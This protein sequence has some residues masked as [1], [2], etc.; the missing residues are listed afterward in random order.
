MPSS[1]IPEHADRDFTASS[2]V[3]RD[4]KVLLL[5]HRKLGVW[6]QPGGHIVGSELPHE[7]ARRETREETGYEIEF[8]EKPTDGV[9]EEEGAFDLPKPIEIN[10]HRIEA[11]HWHCDFAFRAEVVGVHEPSHGEEQNGLKWFDIDELQSDEFDIPQN[12]RS[13]AINALEVD[14]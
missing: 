2:Y 3:I 6:L 9:Y 12:V 11:G 4:G 7:T 1:L 10:V 13:A 8:M 14:S 5:N